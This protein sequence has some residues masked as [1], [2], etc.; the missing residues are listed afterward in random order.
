MENDA[1]PFKL[2]TL[3]YKGPNSSVYTGMKYSVVNGTQVA[4]NVIIKS[5]FFNYNSNN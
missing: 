2:H 1:G 3:I 4:Q 5:T